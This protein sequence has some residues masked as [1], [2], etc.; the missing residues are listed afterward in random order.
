MRNVEPMIVH[1]MKKPLFSLIQEVI[2]AKEGDLPVDPTKD[3]PPVEK[4]PK[5]KSV[6]IYPEKDIFDTWAT[7]SLTPQIATELMKGTKAYKK[8]YPMTLRPQAHDII[9]F[10]LFNTVV[11]SQLHNKKNP[12]RDVVISGHAQDPHGRKM[13]K[14]LGN[15]VEP[16]AMVDKYS[17]DALRF[18]AAGS[19]LGDDMPFQEKDLVTG[20]KFITKLWNASKFVIMNIQGYKPQKPKKLRTVDKWLLSR[21]AQVIKEGTEKFEKYEYSKTKQ[22]VEKFFWHTFCDYYLELAK[23]RMYNPGEHSAE[24]VESAKYTLYTANFAV[25]KLMAPIMPHITEEIFHLH[26]AKIE[27]QK[28]IHNSPWPKPEKIDNDALQAG[29]IVVYALDCARRAKTDRQLSLKA[30]VKRLIIKG[31]IDAKHFEKVKD[32][33][34]AATNA[35]RLEYE[36]LEGDIEFEDIV[37]L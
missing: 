3:A 18:W 6:N 9:T 27:G 35:Q 26:Y 31:K 32:D 2:P 19:K 25:L 16:Q 30:P 15:I 34:A 36:Q 37:D 12:W 33:I 1:N 14:S 28:S 17:S 4:C 21:L 13:S 8:L 5:C 10:W 20:Q 24:D 11:K 23:N 7:S 22:E 29:D